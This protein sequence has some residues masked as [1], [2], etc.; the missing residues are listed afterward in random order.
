[1]RTTRSGILSL[2]AD[3]YHADGI[4]HDQPSLSASIAHTLVTS[5]PKHAWTQ[6]PRLNPDFVRVEDDKFSIGTVAHA[7]LLQGEDIAEIVDAPDWRTNAAK[8]QRDAARAAGRIPL[9]AKD[10]NRVQTM[11]GAVR[12]QFDGIEVAPPLFDDGKP[13][14]PI[15][16]EEDGVLCRALIDWLRRDV[17]A[18]DDAKTT[19][20]CADGQAWGRSVM[21]SIGADLQARWYQRGVKAVFGVEPKFRFVVMETTPP[22]AISV[23]SLSAQAEAIADSKIERAL[24]IWKDCLA[25][26]EWPAYSPKLQVVD[27]PTWEEMR[28]LERE[29]E[30]A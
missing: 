8:E 12:A 27:V 5:S 16:W 29:A 24:T 2:P 10:W 17:T 3:D 30:A 15:V 14:V 22:Y 18:I 20:R 9:L 23:V 4:D 1:M 13:E 28:W 11:V 19:A 21:C 25:K 26:N 6:H 7:L